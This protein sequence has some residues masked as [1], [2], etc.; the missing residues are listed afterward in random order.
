[1]IVIKESLPLEILSLLNAEE[2]AVRTFSTNQF[3]A[4]LDF[5]ECFSLN[6][7][8]TKACLSKLENSCEFYDLSFSGW[9]G[10]FG[11]EFLAANL[12]LLL[13]SDCDLDIEDGWFGRPQTIIHFRNE[14]TCIESVIPNREKELS[15]QLKLDQL[16]IKGTKNFS[17]SSLN[18]NL[19]YDQY[20]KIFHKAKEAILDGESYQ[21]KISQRYEAKAKID[22]IIAFNKLYKANPAPH[23]FLLKTNS[24]S[25]VSCSPE[26]VIQKTDNQIITRPIGG[27]Y[28]RFK[29]ESRNSVVQK[30]LNDKKEVAEHNMLVDLERNDLSTICSPG[31]VRLSRF[32]EVET[33]SHLH[34]LVSTIEGR[35][36]NNI[37][38][39]DIVAAMLPG[40]SITGCPKFRTME[41]IDSLEPCFRGPYTGSF[42]LIG[43]NGDLSLNLIIRSMLS[44]GNCCYMQSGGGIVINSNPEYEFNENQ[45]K[46]KA[47]LELLS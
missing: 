33:Y 10:F 42:G 6:K 31:T 44:L 37:K 36:R 5:G 17:H 43:D 15:K 26:I 40:G 9:V 25:I 32:R 4:Y 41:W 7:K 24:F 16:K 18:C 20:E 35:L 29:G 22:P 30:F 8:E 3:I 19:S 38:L 34:H 1:M 14:E 28:E 27:T 39:W 23:A 13:E 47:L 21:I 12:G 11:Y 46:A 2:L 45:L